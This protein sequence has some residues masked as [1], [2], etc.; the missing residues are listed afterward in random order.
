MC[1]WRWHSGPKVLPTPPK[2]APSPLRP[3]TLQRPSTPPPL[4]SSPPLP[5]PPPFPFFPKPAPPDNWSIKAKRRKVQGTGR[6]R[7]LGSMARRFKNGLR[8]RTV[9][10]SAKKPAAQ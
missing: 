5:A 8:E 7:H 9:A 2:G 6:M 3:L 1:L 10:V 4:P